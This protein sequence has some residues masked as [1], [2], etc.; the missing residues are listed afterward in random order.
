[1]LAAESSVLVAIVL[2]KKNG[3]IQDNDIGKIALCTE[4]VISLLPGIL[5]NKICV[6]EAGYRL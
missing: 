6:P 1:M 5:G 4:G 3:P 2:Q